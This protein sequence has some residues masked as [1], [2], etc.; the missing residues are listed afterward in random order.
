MNRQDPSRGRRLGHEPPAGGIE[1]DDVEGLGA[2]AGIAA[3]RGDPEV[4]LTGGLVT[5]PAGWWIL[6]E[7][8]LHLGGGALV[9]CLTWRAGHANG[10]RACLWLVDP[11]ARALEIHRIATTRRSTAP[12]GTAPRVGLIRHQGA[13]AGG[14]AM[15]WLR[16]ILA[17]AAPASRS[18][19]SRA[20][21]RSRRGT[22]VAKSPRW[23]ATR[24]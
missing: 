5:R 9:W 18:P 1:L 24:P 7:P 17:I 3:V 15:A 16:R 6:D 14:G 2:D 22:A 21:A 20:R 10:C 13:A 11:L 8:E 23:A 19:G 12:S 4:V